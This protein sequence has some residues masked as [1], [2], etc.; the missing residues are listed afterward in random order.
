M[1]KAVKKVVKKETEQPEV[2]N[3][4]LIIQSSSNGEDGWID[5]MPEDLPDWLINGASGSHNLSAMIDGN[6]VC[7]DPSKPYRWYRALNITDSKVLDDSG[8]IIGHT[9][10][11][12]PIDSKKTH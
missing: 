8:K 6:I 10:D 9:S 5:H 7:F 4:Q 2:K 1:T 3:M 12:M 11:N